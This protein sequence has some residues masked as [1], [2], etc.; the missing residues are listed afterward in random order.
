MEVAATLL[1]YTWLPTAAFLDAYEYMKR[2][3]VSDT[4]SSESQ[5][6]SKKHWQQSGLNPCNRVNTLKS[7]Q[8]PGW[9][10][11]GS[12]RQGTQ[13]F[14]LPTFLL[15]GLA[16]LRIDVFIPDQSRHPIPLRQTLDSSAAFYLRD[17][18]VTRL[19]IS[20]YILLA[21][22]RLSADRGAFEKSFKALPFGSRIVI[23][24]ISCDI[25]T[26]KIHM[27]PDLSIERQLLSVKALQSM[28][29]LQESLWPPRLGLDQL[30]HHHQI[31]DTISL[32]RIPEKF[33]TEFVV[34]KSSL[35]EIKYLYH[36][37]KLLLTMPP[38]A[39]IIAR[40]LFIVTKKDRY[41]S[42]D[43]VYGFILEYHWR[44]NLANQ[45]EQRRRQGSLYLKDQLSLA[46]QITSTLMFIIKTPARYFS[47][48]KPDNILLSNCEDHVIF[49]DFEQMGN[50]TSF[51]AP[52]I[53]NLE[54]LFKLANSD[55][56]PVSIR[57]T[58]AKLLTGHVPRDQ[59]PGLIYSNPPAGYYKAWNLL[60]PSEQEAAM[61]FSLGKTLWCIFEG[62]GC[63]RNSILNEPMY[64][65]SLEFPTFRRTPM[66]LQQLIRQCTLGSY[67]WKDSNI[68]IVRRGSFCY[69]RGR[70][71]VD[72]EAT[73][74]AAEALEAA[75]GMWQGKMKDSKLFL[76]ARDRWLA[77]INCDADA[78]L[79]GYPLRP[80]LR[81]VLVTLMKFDE[82]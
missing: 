31:H 16:P 81:D 3:H 7:S 17:K 40:P 37:L 75:K 71:G 34:F 47:E 59:T 66:E 58:H 55:I 67:E 48:L 79:L 41:G 64:G 12:D 14:A 13:F 21:L 35:S 36:E 11:E 8:A 78:M 42:D 19:G 30:E 51:S 6:I 60:N 39:N 26:I 68:D 65:C 22:E 1:P 23:E 73:A 9:R 63:T 45:L 32:V 70:S 57:E 77:G 82:T 20:Q 27:V 76:E 15:P 72:G 24:E 74:S 28:W 38:H 10:I 56:I 5:N 29:H 69:P 4:P 49:I 53:H 2:H 61:V 43:K 52:E 80:K 44:G 46:R 25:N 50:W 62:Y 54:Y 33:G 18:R